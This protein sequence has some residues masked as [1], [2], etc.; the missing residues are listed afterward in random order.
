MTLD[1][2]PLVVALA[3]LGAVVLPMNPGSTPEESK[4]LLDRADPALV[5][6]DE[7]HA[8]DVPLAAL[9][10]DPARTGIRPPVIDENDP[11]V[12]FFTSGSSGRP[13][14]V[15]LSHRA[16]LFHAHERVLPRPRS[17]GED[18]GRGVV[19]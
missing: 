19:S 3:R 14:G 9:L 11:H 8:G 6:G 15:E 1:A 16:S 17:H 5:V 7:D 13:K 2:I 18:V 10:A 4:A 12:I